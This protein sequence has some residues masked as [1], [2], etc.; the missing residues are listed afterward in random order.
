MTEREYEQ[1]K[2]AILCM[3]VYTVDEQE[4]VNRNNVLLLIKKFV[5]EEDED[6]K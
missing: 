4:Y 5:Q 6:D 2:C 1:L 3:H